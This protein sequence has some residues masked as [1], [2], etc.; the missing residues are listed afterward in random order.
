MTEQ[1]GR[2]KQSKQSA[3]RTADRQAEHDA[4]RDTDRN[5]TDRNST[6]QNKEQHAGRDAEA[7]LESKNGRQVDDGTQRDANQKDQS[8]VEPTMEL[9]AAKSKAEENWERY[10]RAAAEVENI[11][12]RS[13]RDV[14]HA[15]KF[16]LEN[17]ARDLLDVRDSLEMGLEAAE[18]ADA[19]A[20][21]EGSA[22][23]LRLLATTFERYGV[24]V[25]DPEGEP[26]DPELH[27]AMS[28]VPAPD[29][30]PGSVVNVIQKGYTLNGRLLRPARVIVAAEPPAP[31][32]EQAS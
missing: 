27:E 15:R 7:D 6:G 10:L 20:I 23:T 21:A 12:K 11:R 5:S 24:A 30:E 22:A 26:F 32:G 18:S 8:E 19:N 9:E 3:G 4:E 1:A 31:E 17:F 2:S 16:A 13:A 28:M 29:T 14:E 25:V